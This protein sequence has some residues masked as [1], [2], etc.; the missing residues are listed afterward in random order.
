MSENVYLEQYKAGFYGVLQWEDLDK[1]WQL[2]NEDN[3]WYVYQVGEPVPETVLSQDEFAHYIENLDK[4]LREEHSERYCGIV[5]IDHKEAP[6]FIKIYDPCNLGSSCGSSG[7]P[8]PLPGW[9]ISKAKPSNLQ[10]AFPVPA[11]RKRWW[12]SLFN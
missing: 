2:L 1:L 12:Q 10:V 4:L 5:Y 3:K 11:K 8:P 7:A 6:S 9:T